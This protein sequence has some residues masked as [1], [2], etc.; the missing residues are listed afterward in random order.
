MDREV[1]YFLFSN[2]SQEKFA[3]VWFQEGGNNFFGH[4]VSLSNPPELIEIEGAPLY[5]IRADVVERIL[6]TQGQT[7]DAFGN[8]IPLP[9]Q[10]HEAA[11][12][13]QPTRPRRRQDAL[14]SMEMS[15]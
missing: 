8:A 12:T 11:S 1:H 7:L 9:D 14:E 2:R 15:F 13:P 4:A 5:A 3:E 6:N 10:V